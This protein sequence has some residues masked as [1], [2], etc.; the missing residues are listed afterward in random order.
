[1]LG[2]VNKRKLIA[3]LVLLMAVLAFAACA[4]RQREQVAHDPADVTQDAVLPAWS[5]ASDCTTCHESEVKSGSDSACAY[6][7]HVTEGV[8]CATCHT[9]TD[10]KLTKA[11]DNYATDKLPT[12]LKTTKVSQESCLTAGCHATD[13]LKTLTANVT[14]LKDSEGTIVNPHDLPDVEGHQKGA[15]A[16]SNCHKMHTAA[17]L[18]DTAQKACLS[19]HHEDVYACYTCHE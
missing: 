9:D 17:D 15:A 14:V 4:P 19:C 13:E 3:V 6:A 11:H 7:A 2:S 1:M 18:A 8:A 10:G 5:A 12:K 16:C